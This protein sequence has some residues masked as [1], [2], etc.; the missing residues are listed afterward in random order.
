MNARIAH[1]LPIGIIELMATTPHVPALLRGTETHDPACKL[2]CQ[3]LRHT[4]DRQFIHTL[5]LASL[6]SNYQGNTPS[7]IESMIEWAIAN[8]PAPGPRPKSGQTAAQAAMEIPAV[9]DM[10]LFHTSLKEAY[11]S[12]TTVAGGPLT[13]RLKEEMFKL[14]LQGQ[15]YATFKRSLSDKIIQEIIEQL[16]ARALFEGPEEVVHL[17]YAKHES[18]V[19]VDLGDESGAA[20]RITSTG[21]S[22]ERTH[23]VRFRR[24]SGML[25]LPEPVEGGDICTLQNLTGLEDTNWKRV[26]AFL[27]NCMRPGGP[28]FALLIE[29]QQGSGKSVRA[30]IIKRIVDP[31]RLDRIRLPSNEHDLIIQAQESLLLNFDN[32]SRVSNNL[33]DSLCALLTRTSFGTRKYY[34]DNELRI[35]EACRPVV[36][37]G[38]GEYA[39]RPDLVDRSIPLNLPAITGPRSTEDE[40]QTKLT[41]I[42]PAM[43]GVFYNAVSR[44]LRK[45]STV[46][47]DTSIRMADAARW[48]TAAEEEFGFVSGE[49]VSA[50]LEGQ[51]VLL[52]DVVVNDPL[53]LALMRIVGDGP[54]TGMM[55]D[56]HECIRIVGENEK[57]LPST[58][59]HLSNA[60]QR[61]V[62]AGASLGLHIELL[63]RS[64]KGRQVRVWRD[65]QENQKS[66]KWVRPTP[67]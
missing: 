32:T 40:L 39:R 59:A 7:E 17:R 26:V 56:L 14:W 2:V 9:R 18:D 58:A 54:Y 28:F 20:V 22:I 46:R 24:G 57:G 62:P 49:L 41:T 52:A 13:L 36:I 16:S 23:D 8:P 50:I 44:A 47:L 6:P 38:I 10:H 27:V 67:I 15:H 61:L 51:S 11:A 4:D 3:L 48:I 55:S 30:S 31:H 25:A 43:L 63:T 37:N 5:V 60:L 64:H 29:G 12:V 33:S 53:Y 35:I 21:W 1:E 19:W 65:G 42:L 66:G 34:T 45:W